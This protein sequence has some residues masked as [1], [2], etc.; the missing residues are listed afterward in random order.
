METGK[1]GVW[2]FTEPQPAAQAG[3]FAS[4]LPPETLA[5]RVFALECEIYPQAIDRLGQGRVSVCGRDTRIESESG[6]R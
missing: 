4:R 5:R 2:F 1:L 6:S 3:E